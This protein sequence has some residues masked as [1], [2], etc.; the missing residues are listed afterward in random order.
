MWTKKR[1]RGDAEEGREGRSRICRDCAH[2][3]EVIHGL[4]RNLGRHVDSFRNYR[5][6]GSFGI[7]ASESDATKLDASR[8]RYVVA[9][10]RGVKT[11]SEQLAALLVFS[12]NRP[13]GG[14]DELR[15]AGRTGVRTGERFVFTRLSSQR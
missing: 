1:R 6:E 3:D 9:G 2:H 5:F 11:T 7:D 12:C 8:Q 13:P 15:G 14:R 4:L 10:S